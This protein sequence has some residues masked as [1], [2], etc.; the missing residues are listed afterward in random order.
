MCEFCLLFAWNKEGRNVCSVTK[1][2]EWGGGST[3]CPTVTCENTVYFSFTKR[4]QTLTTAGA[5]LYNL[6]LSCINIHLSC[7]T[8]FLDTIRTV[9][10]DISM[11]LLDIRVQIHS[12]ICCMYEMCYIPA[13]HAAI[14]LLL[15][16]TILDIMN[17]LYMFS[18]DKRHTVHMQII[19]NPDSSHWTL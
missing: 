10:G 19:S 3:K 18:W 8:N 11:V 5:D 13:Q 16:S 12:W 15:F 7:S 1:S 14:K 17:I 2:A 9:H 6:C 4:E